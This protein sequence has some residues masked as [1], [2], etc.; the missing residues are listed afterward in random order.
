MDQNNVDCGVL[1]L[2]LLLLLLH[3]CYRRIIHFDLSIIVFALSASP[4]LPTYTPIQYM[5]ECECMYIHTTYLSLISS[6]FADSKYTIF[7]IDRCSIHF[8]DTNQPTS[9]RRRKGKNNLLIRIHFLIY[10]G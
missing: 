6:T 8:Y 10:L 5:C 9:M 1:L 2:L 4:L 7:N 3:M